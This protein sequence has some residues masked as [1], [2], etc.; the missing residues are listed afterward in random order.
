MQIVLTM[1]DD[2]LKVLKELLLPQLPRMPFGRSC[3]AERAPPRVGQIVVND[4]DVRR[5]PVIELAL[6]RFQLVFPS[7]DE[8]I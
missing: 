5:G 1:I 8:R 7:I 6:D 2:T 3:Q 4:Q